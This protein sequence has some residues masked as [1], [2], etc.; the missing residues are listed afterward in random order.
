MYLKF[1]RHFDDGTPTDF[2]NKIL[3]DKKLHTIRKGCK[4]SK[5]MSI[6]MLF[7]IKDRA[8][9]ETAKYNHF[10]QQREDLQAVVSIQ[11]IEME[12]NLAN[13]DISMRLDG[14]KVSKGIINAIIKNDGMSEM[15]FKD[16]FFNYS[17]TFTGQLIH[18]T[19][20]KYTPNL[21]VYQLANDLIFHHK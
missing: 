20:L 14:V 8:F 19:S 16:F 1:K 5:G 2:K 3:K 11:T 13:G 9:D 4:W 10:N 7:E 17:N 21:K 12:Y 18:W 15:Q 6:E